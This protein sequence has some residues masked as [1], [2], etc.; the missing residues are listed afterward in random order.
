M[1]HVSGSMMASWVSGKIISSSGVA[2]LRCLVLKFSQ[3]DLPN[4][5]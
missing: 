4:T 5:V 1:F 3:M 2:A